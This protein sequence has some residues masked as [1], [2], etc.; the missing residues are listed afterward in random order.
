M[1][2]NVWENKKPLLIGVRVGPIIVSSG[3][4]YFLSC[5]NGV[6]SLYLSTILSHLEQ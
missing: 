6:Y 4:G 2:V 3:W 1:G 5:L